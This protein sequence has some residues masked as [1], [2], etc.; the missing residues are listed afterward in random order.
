MTDDEAVRAQ[1]RVRDKTPALAIWIDDLS[2]TMSE[3]PALVRAQLWPVAG[4]PAEIE[5]ARVFS[6]HIKLNKTNGLAAR[7]ASAALSVPG[8]TGLLKKGLEKEYKDNLY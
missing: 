3:S 6:E 8:V 2:V 1:F 5:P 7:L 4:R